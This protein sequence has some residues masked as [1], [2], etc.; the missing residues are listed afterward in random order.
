MGSGNRC[1][2]FLLRR[3]GFRVDAVDAVD[4][5]EAMW[6]TMWI[7]DMVRGEWGGVFEEARGCGR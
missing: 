2:A 1:W 7:G 5:A 4:N 3:M 6:R